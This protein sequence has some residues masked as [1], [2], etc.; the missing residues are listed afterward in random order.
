MKG[1]TFDIEKE[2]ATTKDMMHTPK[3]LCDSFPGTELGG[4]SPRKNL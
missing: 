1:G 2:L 3:T 4:I